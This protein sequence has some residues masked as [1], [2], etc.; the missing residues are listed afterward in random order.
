MAAA[1]RFC[2]PAPSV[3]APGALGAFRSPDSAGP[4]APGAFRAGMGG[5]SG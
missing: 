4:S 1:S 3:K 5:A 2:P